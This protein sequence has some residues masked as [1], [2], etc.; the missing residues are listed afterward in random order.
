MLSHMI[1]PDED[2]ITR[3]AEELDEGMAC[4]VHKETGVLFPVADT[5]ELPGGVEGNK[6]S[7]FTFEPPGSKQSYALMAAFVETLPESRW[8][9]RLTDALQQ[10]R[11]F[12]HF[13]DEIAHT[14]YVDEWKS[15]RLSRIMDMV[16]EQWQEQTQ[17]YMASDE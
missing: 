12:R 4:L 14:P 16:R 6:D 13:R 7:F 10:D 9:M 3:I 15:F 11:P 17:G 8:H 5:D 2:R 1:T